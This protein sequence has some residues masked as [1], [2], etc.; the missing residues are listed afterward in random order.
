MALTNEKVVEKVVGKLTEMRMNF[1]PEE[2]A[3]LDEMIIGGPEVV[4]HA[5]TADKVVPRVI[6][7]DDKYRIVIP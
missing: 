5:V 6:L 1:G 4:A 7:E 3:V 2:R